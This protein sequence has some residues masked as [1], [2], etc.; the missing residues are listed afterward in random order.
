MAEPIAEYTVRDFSAVDT[1][2]EQIAERERV[3]TQKLRLANLFQ[4][5]KFAV[6]GLVALG[7]FF[8]LLGIA[9]RIAFPPEQ[10]VVETT[11]IVEKI[12][13]TPKIVIQTPD[14]SQV[15]QAQPGTNNTATSHQQGD[16]QILDEQAAQRATQE[17][18]QRLNNAGVTNAGSK[19]SASLSW[20]NYNDLDLMVKE[21]N[22]N[23]VFFKKKRSA[24]SGILDVDANSNNSTRRSRTPVENIRWSAGKAPK[25]EYIVSVLFYGKSP[26]EPSTGATP[27]TVKL[28]HNGKSEVRQGAF[29]NNTRPQT[30]MEIARL[31]VE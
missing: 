8:L 26:D 20:N 21:P 22:G 12:I 30:P 10:K 28:V 24:T 3:V 17:I 25:G 14:G 29:P 13:Q 11:K 9:Y 18:D 19:V 1:Q 5:V 7:V 27:F 23:M 4:L 31:N 16:V 6:I 2:I 15:V